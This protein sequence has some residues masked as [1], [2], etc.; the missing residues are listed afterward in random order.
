[1]MDTYTYLAKLRNQERRNT[2][3]RRWCRVA[4]AIEKAINK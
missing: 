1:M 2:N 3:L 4:W